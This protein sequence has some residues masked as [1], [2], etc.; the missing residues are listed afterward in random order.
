M[1]GIF[2]SCMHLGFKN[3]SF[4]YFTLA[5]EGN[6]SPPAFCLRLQEKRGCEMHREGAS[7][8]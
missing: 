2:K 3:P 6:Q 7:F 1:S 5:N 4:V 8:S